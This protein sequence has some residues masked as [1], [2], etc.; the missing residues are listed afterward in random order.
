MLQLLEAILMH[1]HAGLRI[2][3]FNSFPS[4]FDD[5]PENAII[6]DGT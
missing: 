1:L 5:P 4:K 3:S 6:L 2:I